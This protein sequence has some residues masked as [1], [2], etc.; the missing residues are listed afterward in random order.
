[1]TREEL[2][3]WQYEGCRESLRQKYGF[4]NR[5]A[6]VVDGVSFTLEDAVAVL[7]FRF[8]NATGFIFPDSQYLDGKNYNPMVRLSCTFNN[9]CKY[10]P[11]CPPDLASIAAAVGSSWALFSGGR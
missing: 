9:E 1:M 4:I 3:V 8:G 2:R 6:V 7:S 11:V 5:H 10:N